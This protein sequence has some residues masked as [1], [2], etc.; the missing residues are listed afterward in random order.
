MAYFVG[1]SLF[2]VF[3]KIYLGFKVVGRENVPKKGAFLFVSNHSSYLDPILLGTSLYRGLYYMA[4]E[5]LFARPLSDWIIRSV[6]AFPVK[7]GKGDL[8]ALR[9][10]LGILEGGKPLA[11]FPE[12][13]RSPDGKLRPVKPGV[14][15]IAAKSG[16]PI[17]PVYIDG[18]WQAFSKNLK[19]LRRYPVTVYIGE[20]ITFDLAKGRE[21]REVYQ[22]ISDE[23]MA[24]IAAL[25]DRHAGKAG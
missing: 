16:V 19:T 22:K 14:G 5:S 8:G 21:G 4:R 3:F 12:G 18:S 6:H 9:Q 25:K 23:I 15:F 11:M 2:L 24:K 7:R 20:P 17:V 10:A 1:W 13:A